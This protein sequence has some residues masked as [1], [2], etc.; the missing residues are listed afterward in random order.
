[1]G[2]T[3]VHP[4]FKMGLKLFL[5][6]SELFK[7]I[8]GLLLVIF[9]RLEENISLKYLLFGGVDV[10]PPNAQTMTTSLMPRLVK[11]TSRFWIKSRQKNFNICKMLKNLSILIWGGASLKFQIPTTLRFIYYLL[12]SLDLVVK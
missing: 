7:F 10:C 6:D 4:I 2:W 5:I 8:F 11:M 12:S 3:Y 1:M 9:I